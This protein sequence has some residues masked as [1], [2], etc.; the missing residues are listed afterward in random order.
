M[1]WH[2]YEEARERKAELESEI[3]RRRARGEVFESLEVPQGSRKLTKSFW[4]K[5]WNEQLE[6]HQEYEFRLPRGRSYLRQGNVYNLTIE[7]GLISATV[8]GASLY[9][10]V[11]RITPLEQETWD[12]IK[13]DCLGQ[14][15][16]LLDLLAG[17]LGDG[18]LRAI[19][20]PE[21]GL[22]PKPKEIRFS[23][24]C[25]DWADMCKHVAAVLYGVGVRLDSAPDLFF[26]LRSVDPSELLTT[27]A[28]NALS[29]EQPADSALAG[30]D[31]SALFGI[32]L[33]GGENG[34]PSPESTESRRP[35]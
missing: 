14:V 30:E 6:L 23:C 35:E 26:V 25:P 20:D 9:D 16:S 29:I 11:V 21:R 1:S 7:P 12:G 10:V 28:Q 32:D 33:L 2:A 5:A 8:A 31:L 18:V 24:S 19:I 34:H 17:K 4:G 13:Q 22:F 27:T 3:K 15:A